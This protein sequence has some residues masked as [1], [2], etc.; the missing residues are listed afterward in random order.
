MTRKRLI[1]TLAVATLLV[2]AGC[3]G[4]IGDSSADSPAD[5]TD[6]ADGVDDHSDHS[7]RTVNVRASG[8][9]SADP[10]RAIL[11]VAVQATADDP[12]TARQRLSENVST[13]RS[14]LSEAGIPDDGIETAHYVIRQDRESRQTEGVTRYVA[15]H[16]FE[17]ETDDVD[18][19]GSVIET[20]VNNG[21]TDVHHVEFT[22]S[23]EA[24]NDLREDALSAAM[25]NARTDADI[26]AENADLSI[27]GVSSVS[28]GSVDVRPYHAEAMMA[29]ADAGGTNVESGPVTVS[30][31]VQVTYNATAA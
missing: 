27:A 2:T 17:V 23:E 24:R 15:I 16:A 25:E 7:D 1:A 6:A 4:A 19:V 18:G 12:E 26:L 3:L 11:D 31:Q 5:T 10:D 22:L 28:T 21:A 13:M 9:V 8:E 29:S 20:A 14:A 30:A